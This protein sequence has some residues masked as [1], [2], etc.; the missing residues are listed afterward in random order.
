MGNLNFQHVGGSNGHTTKGMGTK[1]TIPCN[2]DMQGVEDMEECKAVFRGAWK[3]PSIGVHPP[4]GMQG[5][6]PGYEGIQGVVPN[7]NIMWQ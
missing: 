1:G 6:A 4:N 5:E 2:Q 7:H 3:Y